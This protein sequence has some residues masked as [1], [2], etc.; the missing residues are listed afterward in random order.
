MLVINDDELLLPVL[1]WVGLEKDSVRLLPLL[2][3]SYAP[4]DSHPYLKLEK[5]FKSV[6][7]NLH[8]NILVV[9]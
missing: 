6:C 7:H 3:A 2:C 4:C 8:A 1:G 9:W 5:K